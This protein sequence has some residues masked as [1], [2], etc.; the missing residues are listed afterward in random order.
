MRRGIGAGR[1]GRAGGVTLPPALAVALF[2]VMA[3]S[4]QAFRS[5]WKRQ[6]PGWRR[7]AWLYALPA[8]ASFL[9]LA[10][11]PLAA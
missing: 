5:T 7:R 8:L 2:V 10:F 6:R 3:V 4:G 11:I 1:C 9:A